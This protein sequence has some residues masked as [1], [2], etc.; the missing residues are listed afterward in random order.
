MSRLDKAQRTLIERFDQAWRSGKSP[1][2][3]RSLP[4]LLAA[5]PGL[6]DADTRREFLT[7]LVSI[8]LEYRWRHGNEGSA[9]TL[10]TYCLE[11]YVSLL[12]SLGSLND[13]PLDLLAAE[14]RARHA[15]GDAPSAASYAERFPSHGAA[16]I[17]RL[18]EVER[19]TAASGAKLPR[20]EGLKIQSK[21]GRGSFGVVYKGRQIDAKRT[22]AVKVIQ[23]DSDEDKEA[24][25]RFL[26]EAQSIARIKHPNVVTLY[27]SGMTELKPYLVM[28]YAPGGTLRKRLHE[29]RTK[30]NANLPTDQTKWQRHVASLVHDIA[31]GL[32]AA[33]AQQV[34][35]RDLKPENILFD[36]EHHPMIADFGLAREEDEA[37]ARAAR[38]K[39]LA[40]IKHPNKL[41]VRRRSTC[42]PISI[43]SASFCLKC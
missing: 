28:E 13:L 18:E 31:R 26:K 10:K 38:A 14:Y 1:D 20:I 5:S 25:A 23:I 7:E 3:V 17:A 2:L 16:L 19:E 36:A 43:H 33:H 41:P 29:W 39:E 8:D 22:V 12:P 35:H 30:W 24:F 32:A 9:Q 15:W 34:V 27:H 6:K 42:E 37:L 21:I 11:E 4:K 40:S